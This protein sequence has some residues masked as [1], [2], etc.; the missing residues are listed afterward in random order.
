MGEK[1]TLVSTNL[2]RNAVAYSMNASFVSSGP[3][4]PLGRL[5]PNPRL[6]FL[7]QC[8]E[9]LRFKQ[10]ALRGR[11]VRRLDS[12]FHRVADIH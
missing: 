3:A 8:H 1:F 4:R 9:E 5:I 11:I 7:D 6:R 10:M 2:A 12:A